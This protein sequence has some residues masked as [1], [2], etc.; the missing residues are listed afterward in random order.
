MSDFT[1]PGGEP[2]RPEP[3]PDPWQ[4]AYGTYGGPGPYD[5]TAAAFA[6]ARTSKKM[7]GWGLGLSLLICV[8]FAPLVGLVLGIVVLV[9]ARDGR[10]H[11]KGLG[12]AAVVIGGLYLV[13]ALGLVV[14]GFVAAIREEFDEPERDEAGVIQHEQEIQARHLRV[15]DCVSRMEL[16]EELEPGESPTGLVTVVPCSSLHHSEVF[17]VYDIEPD[18]Y[19]DQDALDLASVEGCL[20]EFKAYVGRPFHRS[21]LELNYYGPTKDWA[22]LADNRVTCLVSTPAGHLSGNMLEDSRR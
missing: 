9:R 1:P 15:G 4:G 21:S 12:V 5:D 18:D 22:P 3:A 8:P 16:A 2:P 13:A 6:R 20:P 10:D 11:G 7:A 14:F 17:H 19:P